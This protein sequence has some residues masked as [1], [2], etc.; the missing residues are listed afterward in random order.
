MKLF[1]PLLTT[2]AKGMGFGFAICKLIVEAHGGKITVKTAKDRGTVFT[3][4][5][6]FE[7]KIEVGGEKIWVNTRSSLS[8][9]TKT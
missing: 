5:L 6:P 7:P 9:T 8:M 2:K 4:T 1:S 3:V